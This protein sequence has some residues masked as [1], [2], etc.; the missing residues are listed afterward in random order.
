MVE[1]MEAG[2]RERERG[3]GGNGGIEGEKGKE[4]ENQRTS[5]LVLNYMH[6]KW[7]TVPYIAHYL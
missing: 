7:N 4:G 2:E 5:A 3:G 6:P 1:L